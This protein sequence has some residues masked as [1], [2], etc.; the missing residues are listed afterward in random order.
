M[1]PLQQESKKGEVEMSNKYRSKNPD[2]LFPDVMEDLVRRTTDCWCKKADID[3]L[4]RI[5]AFVTHRCNLFC[6]YCNGPHMTLKEGDTERKRRMLKHDMT[7]SKFQRILD[8]ALANYSGIR[9]IHFTGGEPTLNKDLPIFI[10]MTTQRGILTSITTNGTAKPN[11]Y[12]DL[13]GKGLTEIRISFD[14][15]SAEI[16]DTMVGVPG[17]FEKIVANIKEITR[18]RD[19]ENQDIFLV[20]NACVDITNLDQIEETLRFLLSLNPDDIKFLVVAQDR[21]F[22]LDHKD[23]IVVARLKDMLQEYPLEKYPLLRVKIERMFDPDAVGLEDQQTQDLMEH[24]F[25]PMTGRTLDG[26]HYYPCSIYLRYFGEPTGSLCD[27]SQEQR[28]K[29]LKFVGEHD[30]RQDPICRQFCINC[31]KVFNVR[32][33]QEVAIQGLPTIKV[34]DNISN[35]EITELIS[36]IEF[37][38]AQGEISDRPFMII[39]PRGQ[40]WRDEII[41]SL[42]SE[43]I[44]IESISQIQ[45][46]QACAKYLYCWPLNPDKVRLAILKN[47]AFQMLEKGSAEVLYFKDDPSPETLTEIKYKLRDVF[48]NQRFLL[49]I[50]G[51]ESISRHRVTVIHTPN[52][53]DLKRENAILSSILSGL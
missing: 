19:E 31:C 40:Q 2:L 36:R 29:T 46:W 53:Q 9:H 42:L 5:T 39:K 50:A 10:E 49:Q 13:I 23:E 21:Q 30:C 26:E 41:V 25:L 48:P 17:S 52:P 20:V 12:S 34:E 6:Q 18:L 45:N 32:T 24:C 47:K 28:D 44:E 14:A 43:D 27:S 22:V 11:L 3:E 35:Q 15:H 1:E 33:N 51:N 4:E 7:I 37:L 38:I 16:F 8:E